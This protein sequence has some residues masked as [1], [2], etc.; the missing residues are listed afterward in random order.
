MAG[1]ATQRTFPAG[2][3]TSPWPFRPAYLPRESARHRG[4]SQGRRGKLY[5]MGFAVAWCV[6]LWLM[7]NESRDWRIYA[8]FAQIPDRHCARALVR[9]RSPRHRPRSEP[10]R[11]GF[12]DYRSLSFGLPIGHG[13]AS[14]KAQ[15]RCIHCWIWHGNIPTFI[16]ITNGKVHDVN[17][18]RS[19]LA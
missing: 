10:V 16:R 3:S 15:S 4:M 5:H 18:P 13:S 7:A 17:H 11:A 12:D 1:I 6:P 2:I 9:Q 8:D 19:A 14:T